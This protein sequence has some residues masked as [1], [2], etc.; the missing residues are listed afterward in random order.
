MPNLKEFSYNFS[1]IDNK[2]LLFEMFYNNFSQYKN[3]FVKRTKESLQLYDYLK[4]SDQLIQQ[5]FR[6]GGETDV[7]LMVIVFLC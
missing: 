3:F 2:S 1:Q 5:S 4:W 6:C 7:Y